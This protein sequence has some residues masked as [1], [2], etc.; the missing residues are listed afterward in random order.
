MDRDGTLYTVTR[1][2]EPGYYFR[3]SLHRKK[4][5]QPWEEPQHLAIPFKPYYKIWM[6]KLV[7]DP[8]RERLFLTYWSQS[9]AECLFQDEY[10][11]ALFIWPD[12]EQAWLTDPATPRSLPTPSSG[13]SR[14]R[15]RSA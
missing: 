8:V 13:G 7:L 9:L 6:H 2:A 10:L 12:R 14:L 4:S 1:N 15:R 11:A 3:L 5:G